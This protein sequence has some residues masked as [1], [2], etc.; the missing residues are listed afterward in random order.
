M[1]S[2]PPLLWLLILLAIAVVVGFVALFRQKSN[3]STALIFAAEYRE[4]V[5]ELVVHE[6][7]VYE[8]LMLNA[9]R[10]QNQ[11]GGQGLV[12]F[13]PPFSNYVVNNY[14]VV[15]NVLSELRKCLSDQTL[16]MNLLGQYHAVL[17]DALLRHQGSLVERREHALANLRNPFV[18][19]AFGFRT[20]LAAPLWLLVALGIFPR[21]L[22]SRL[23]SSH[24]Y[25]ILSGIV[26]GIG[27]VSAVVGLVTGWGQFVLILQK[28]VPNAF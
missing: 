24:I 11:M 2:L 15:L 18:W 8:W 16:S 25:R 9:N 13:R 20:I 22:A 4:R 17:D 19:L 14:P 21:S 7:D 12:A 26:A 3:I 27:F 1:P 10:M 28:A 23:Q 5:N 6:A